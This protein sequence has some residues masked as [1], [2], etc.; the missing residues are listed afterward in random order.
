MQP[1]SLP[2]TAPVLPFPKDSLELD[3]ARSGAS[4]MFC[5]GN[6]C[7]ADM[8]EKTPRGDDR[9]L[10]YPKQQGKGEEG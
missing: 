5:A 6:G 1:A 2:C 4:R 7:D 10:K 3:E 9:Q 8:D